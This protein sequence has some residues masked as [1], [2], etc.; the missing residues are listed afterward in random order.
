M[1]SID[2][3]SFGL[4]DALFDEWD[5]LRRGESTPQKASAISRLAMAAVNSVKI[6]IEYQKHVQTTLKNT[7]IVSNSAIIQLGTGKAEK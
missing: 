4:R 3:T 5:A 7:E 2:R 1:K 6:E